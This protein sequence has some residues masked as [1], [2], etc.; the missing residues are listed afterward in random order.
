MRAIDSYTDKIEHFEAMTFQ[1]RRDA[2]RI[3]NLDD[4]QHTK[5]ILKAI[6]RVKPDP[7][8]VSEFSYKNSWGQCV[9]CFTLNQ[10]VK[11]REPSKKPRSKSQIPDCS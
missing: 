6:F 7:D 1:E 2:V 9:E 5:S 8:S 3:A 4:K 11:M 10:C